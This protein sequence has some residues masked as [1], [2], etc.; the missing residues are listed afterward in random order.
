MLLIVALF[1]AVI[2]ISMQ[3]NFVGLEF[4][5]S[6]FLSLVLFICPFLTSTVALGVLNAATSHQDF[7]KFLVHSTNLKVNR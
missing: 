1:C 3:T 4:L 2:N 5:K 7:T 6:F